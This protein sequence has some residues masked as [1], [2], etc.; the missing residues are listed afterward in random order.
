[1]HLKSQ[2]GVCEEQ[3]K[4]E[5]REISDLSWIQYRPKIPVK[6]GIK[7]FTLCKSETDYCELKNLHRK[8]GNLQQPQAGGRVFWHN[9]TSHA[10]FMF[11]Y[12][13]KHIHNV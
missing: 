6:W 4:S 5:I 12:S 7:V 1:M 9:N 3:N 8:E 2:K 10:Q 11:R 13:Q